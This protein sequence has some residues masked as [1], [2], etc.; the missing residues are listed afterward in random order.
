[1][2]D[3]L[4]LRQ[5]SFELDLFEAQLQLLFGHAED[6]EHNTKDAAE[7]LMKQICSTRRVAVDDILKL[8]TSR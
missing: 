5:E 2:M 1:M 6:R 8:D 7:R 4:E 3:V